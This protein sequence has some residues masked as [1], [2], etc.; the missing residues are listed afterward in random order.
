MKFSLVLAT[1]GRVIELRRFL[2]ALEQQTFRD[3][4]LI[5][6]DQNPDERLAE[7]LRRPQLTMIHLHSA[8]GLSLARNRGLQFA[9]GELV[10][11]PDDDCWYPP[12][13]LQRVHEF[14]I[15]HSEAAGLTGRCI[16]LFGGSSHGR[17]DTSAGWVEQFNVFR[18]CNSNTIF[19]RRCVVERVG[20]FDEQLGLGAESRWGS[21][22]DSD[23]ILRAV[24]DEFRIF[25]S[26]DIKIYHN[27][28]PLSIEPA[29][30]ARRLA[31]NRGFGRVLRKHHYPWWFVVYL[32]LRPIGGVL[33]SLYQGLASI[34]RFQ[35]WSA[36]TQSGCTPQPHWRN[37]LRYIM[38][39]PRVYQNWWLWPLPKLGFD[40]VLRLRNGLR[41][42]IRGGTAD[43]SIINEATILNPYL[44]SD[45]IRLAPNAIV[46]DG[47]ANIGD[48]TLQAA[49]RCPVGRVIAVEPVAEHVAALTRN[50][51]LSGFSNIEVLQ[52]A[53]G[54]GEGQ[55][56]IFVSGALSSETPAKP[57]ARSERVRKASLATLMR[58]LGVEHLDLLK[59]DCEGAEWEILP[60][61]VDLFPRIH[62]ICMEYH[63]HAIWSGEMLAALLDNHGYAV[64]LA[65]GRGSGLLW[66]VRR[67]RDRTENPA[68]A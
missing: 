36:R 25:Y 58:E 63:A 46:L 15:N 20:E 29:Q 45:L 35:G 21:G 23:Y 17:W 49:A 39:V 41:Y 59:L 4:E 31:Y 61:S 53:L 8:P 64:T 5:V 55:S 30:Q 3:F 40:I 18:R 24:A 10:C 48:F 54:A 37:R 43:L 7:T 47:G 68:R 38:S 19:L 60:S 22:E 9:K 42:R 52:L 34:G 13:L 57:G 11:F 67:E 12:D 32:I 66:A 65:P 1:V 62:Q 26:P 33:S 2:D 27:D 44:G 16:D 28:P 56:Q 50:I 6:V 51:G 14:F